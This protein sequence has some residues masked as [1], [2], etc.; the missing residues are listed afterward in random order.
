MLLVAWVLSRKLWRLHVRL[1]QLRQL[2]A[3]GWPWGCAM[4]WNV[5]QAACR[6]AQSSIMLALRSKWLGFVCRRAAC[7]GNMLTQ[8]CRRP[9]HDRRQPRAAFL[10]VRLQP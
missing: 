8:R 2:A 9:E 6:G 5:L 4:P 1:V 10:A 3:G 7:R